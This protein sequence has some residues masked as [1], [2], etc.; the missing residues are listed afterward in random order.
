MKFQLQGLVLIIIFAMAAGFLP[1]RFSAATPNEILAQQIESVRKERDALIEEQK[2]LERELEK[3]SQESSNLGSAV[4][5]LDATKKKLAADIKVTQSKIASTDLNIRM[6]ENNV[7]TTKRQIDTHQKAVQTAIKALSD[8]DSRPLLMDILAAA[9]FGEMWK[10][11]S[12][13]AGLSVS[14]ND[15]VKSLE[16][17]KS[18]LTRQKTDKE[19]AKE[20]I[21]ALNQE[22]TGQKSIVEESQKAKERLLAD[23]KNKEA[24]YQKMLADNKARQ[25]QSEKD[26]FNLESELKFNLEPGSIPDAKKGILSWPLDNIF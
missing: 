26:L 16:Q 14:L 11:H 2:R 6:L 24:L 8:A 15:E 5:S 19:K 7:N 20:Q 9:D 21:L 1:E 25:E 3:A 12:E 22:L 17:T 4:K 10:D 13:L 18:D 23:S